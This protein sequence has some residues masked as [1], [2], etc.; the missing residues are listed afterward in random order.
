[1]KFHPKRLG[2]GLLFLLIAGGLALNG[3]AYQQAYAM[4]HYTAGG[5]RTHTPESLRFWKKLRVLRGGVTVPRPFDRRPPSVLAPG[6]QAVTIPVSDP[7]TLSA[8]SCDQGSD[9]PLIILFHG[10]STDKTSLLLEAKTF[11]E[12]GTSVLLVD[13]RGSG[14]SSES[15]TTLGVREAE[16]V[17]AAVRYANENLPHAQLVL[18]GRSMGAA[19]ILRAVQEYAIAPDAVILEAV[20]DTMLHTTRNRFGSMGIPSFPSA[21]LLVFWGG[22]QW[23]FNG[24]AHNPVDYAKSLRCPA[25]F[26]HGTDDPRATLADGRRVFDAV[27][28]PKK[29]FKPFAHTG[30]KSYAARHLTDW[31]DTVRRFLAKQRKQPQ[32][33]GAPHER[34]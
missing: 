15:Y 19:A 4:M 14:G 27:P 33:K 9:T 22:Q 1:M 20:F 28:G 8:W 24:F 31:R 7:I 3:L 29:Q 25:L 13:F 32:P 10:Y 6:T 34:P 23:G 16:D 26:M 11:L 18:F 5:T 21:E 12:L 2:I 17:V 30:H